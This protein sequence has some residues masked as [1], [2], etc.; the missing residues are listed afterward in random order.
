MKY[1]VVLADP[2][3]MFRVRSRKGLSRS[4]ENH[5]S[6]MD[7]ARIAE[8]PV[9]RWGADNSVLLMWATWPTL[10]E[11]IALGH[12]WGFTYK[13][14]GF[15]WAKLIP[16]NWN[17]RLFDV[18]NLTLFNDHIL[19]KLQDIFFCGLGYYTRANTEMCLIFTKGNGLK[20][21]SMAVRQLIVAPVREHSRKPDETYERIEKLFDG[22]YLEL[23]GRRKRP[24]WHVWGNEV[25]SDINLMQPPAEPV[26]PI[27]VRIRGKSYEQQVMFQ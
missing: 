1:S 4:A 9:E 23:F 14:A 19:P 20:R 15:V 25:Q 11:A 17:K 21:K 6:T 16:S 2:P 13:T 26:K 10:V 3:W 12:A 7:T 22:P 18:V 8:L 27:R 5:Y 24:G